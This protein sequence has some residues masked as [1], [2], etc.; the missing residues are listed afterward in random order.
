MLSIFTEFWNF[1]RFFPYQFHMGEKR[2]KLQNPEKI[3]HIPV[4]LIFF[5]L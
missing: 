1:P 3:V 2:V 5:A 4:A